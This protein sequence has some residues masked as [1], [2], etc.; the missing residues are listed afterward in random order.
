MKLQEYRRKRNFRHTAEPPPTARAKAGGSIFV[1]QKHAARRLHYDFRLEI[2]GVLKSWAV[3]KEPSFDPSVKRLAVEVEDHPL[4]YADF[5]GDIPEGNYGAGH[6]DCY[7][8]GVWSAEGDVDQQLRKGHLHFTLHGQRLKGSWH[9]VRGHRKERQPSWFLIKAHDRYAVED[10]EAAGPAA[11]KSA[12][13]GMAKKTAKAVPAAAKHAKASR[14]RTARRASLATLAKQAAALPGARKAAI[15]A[16]YFAPEL[17]RLVEQPPRGDQ[18]LHEVKWDGYRL[19]AAIADG[20]VTLWSRNRIAWTGRVPA[21]VHALELLGL[22]SARLDGELIAIRHGHSDFG[23]L[24]Q[25]LSGESRAPLMYA[26]F[27]LIHLQGHDL[28]RVPLHERKQLLQRLLAAA[29]DTQHQLLFSAHHTGGGEGMLQLAEKWKVEGIVSKLADSPYRGGRGDDWRKSKLM[30]SDEFAVVGY[31]PGKGTREGFGSLLLGRPNA[32]GG[33]DFAGRVGTGFGAEQLRQ[34]AAQLRRHIRKSPPVEQ[35][36]IDPL[37][38]Q[39]TWVAPAVVVEVYFRGYGNHGLL[40]QPSLKTVRLD[41][42]IGDLGQGEGERER[43]SAASARPSKRRRGA[44]SA[45]EPA[46]VTITHPERVI[47]ADLGITKQDVADYYQSVMPVFLPGVAGRPVSVLRCPEGTAGDC[48]FQKHMMKGL[49]HVRGAKLKEQRGDSAIYLCPDDAEAVME[50][51]Q[52]GVLEFHPWGALASDPEH[53]DVM[54][55]DL[56]PAPDVKWPRVVAAARLVRKLLGQVGLASFLRTTGGKGLH[57]VVPLRPACAWAQVKGFAH[58][59]A[60]ALA[61][62]WPDEFIAQAS[63]SRREGLIFVDYLRNAR[64][65]TSIASYSLRARKGAPVAMPLRWDELGKLKGGDAFDIRTAV[66]RLKR[67]RKDPWEGFG[68]IEQGIEDIDASLLSM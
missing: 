12:K 56:D 25:V 31:T 29:P 41:K 26:I 27:D 20:E 10:G 1:V 59:F 17:C 63:K 21:I 45:Q 2:D 23:T 14:Q 68:E 52:F 6:V 36:T 40:R 34:I 51:V 44:S 4:A 65:S 22:D 53:A 8:R 43:A 18:W 16:E 46:M 54:V 62:A 47:Y 55:F 66:Q 60:D 11:S 37:L 32:K 38:R 50:L 42:D 35:D 13:K 30:Q 33:W 19:L 5:E 48:F 39:A 28:S 3:P 7:D 57:V 24:Q 58:A 15:Q 61:R 9:L 67:Q 49:H 64:G